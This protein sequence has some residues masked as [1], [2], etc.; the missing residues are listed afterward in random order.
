MAL[1]ANESKSNHRN[2]SKSNGGN[3]IHGPSKRI[4]I[5]EIFNGFAVYMPA[6]HRG[7]IRFKYIDF[8]TAGKCIEIAVDDIGGK[9][10]DPNSFRLKGLF[11]IPPAILPEHKLK[12]AIGN[13][14]WEIIYRK[15]EVKDIHFFKSEIS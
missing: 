7:Y 12:K 2:E 4:Q 10:R 8:G 13:P 9:Y 6:P 11:A 14:I 3:I 1:I 15:E 5:N